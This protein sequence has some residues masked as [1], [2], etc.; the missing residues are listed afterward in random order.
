M[1]GLRPQSRDAFSRRSPEPGSHAI[2]T[3]IADVVPDPDNLSGWLLVV[4]GLDSSYVDLADPT[5]LEFEYVAWMAAAIDAHLP[6]DRPVR[7]AHLGGG[8]CTLPRYIATA[9][10]DSVQ[11]VLEIDE[12]LIRLVTGIFGLAEIPGLVIQ[13]GDAGVGL[14]R[15]PPSSYD[16]VV[17]DAFVGGSVPAHL[18]TRDFIDEVAT[19]LDEGG[20]YVANVPAGPDLQAAEAEAEIARGSFSEVVLLVDP[21]QLHA[22]RFGNVVLAAAHRPLPRARLATALSQLAAP[23]YVVPAVGDR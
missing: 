16:V 5:H 7:I 18:T 13:P 10:P 3:G 19:V 6:G 8:G 20:M 17:R 4:N 23:A 1:A 2:A 9:R 22:R 14:R 21:G 12:D 15:L 11:L